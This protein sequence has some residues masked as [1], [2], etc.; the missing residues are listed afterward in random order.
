MGV[1]GDQVADSWVHL[2]AVLALDV[3]EVV[4]RAGDVADEQEAEAQM[5]VGQRAVRNES[6]AVRTV[7][8]RTQCGPGGASIGASRM[9]VPHTASGSGV[10]A[11]NSSSVTAWSSRSRLVNQVVKILFS[12]GMVTPSPV[13]GTTR[14][15]V[16][17]VAQTG[18][19][20]RPA[21]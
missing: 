13:G 4:V 16:G 7:V 1:S 19:P 17:N 9:T 12:P 20:V 3:F 2:S 18:Y 11:V 6:R 5:K 8:Q 10:L 14:C 21:R 15:L